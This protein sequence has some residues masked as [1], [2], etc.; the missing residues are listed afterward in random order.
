[1]TSEGTS[2]VAVSELFTTSENAFAFA[3]KHLGDSGE[4]RQTTP[5]ETTIPA[6]EGC[7]AGLVENPPITQTTSPVDLGMASLDDN[8]A[9]LKNFESQF[10][11]EVPVPTRNPSPFSIKG[12]L[13]AV[14][15]FLTL[16]PEEA[17]GALDTKWP[18]E[19]FDLLSKLELH[20]PIPG[21]DM[22]QMLLMQSASSEIKSWFAAIESA[23]EL[24]DKLAREEETKATTHFSLQDELAKG[25][26]T[27]SE[28]ASFQATEAT[29][30]A[31]IDEL[32]A[33]LQRLEEEETRGR[34]QKENLARDLHES[35][36]K[37]RALRA[38]E[39]SLMPT[40]EIA[41]QRA[42]AIQTDRE[43]KSKFAN[44]KASFDEIIKTLD[45]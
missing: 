38:K 26:S 7:Q 29:R 16:S 45:A 5:R 28:V 13:T 8:L 3:R 20:L 32:K 11:T 41:L 24:R 4:R 1:M 9:Y 19:A 35:A 33:E 27:S 18:Q 21:I 14:G 36:T 2:G 31:R 42:K 40:N 25:R 37:I 34:I 44:L 39:E 12:A 6:E 22:E 23:R 15:E 10:L 17:M 30:K 43:N